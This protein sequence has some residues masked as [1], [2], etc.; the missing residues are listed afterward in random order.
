MVLLIELVWVVVPK[1]DAKQTTASTHGP[2]KVSTQP[3]QMVV[4][5]KYVTLGQ[6]R[7]DSVAVK[8]LTPGQVVVSSGAMALRNNQ[9]VKIKKK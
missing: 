9:W 1:T 3:S 2:K 4:K 7:G 5:Q 8:G 6:M